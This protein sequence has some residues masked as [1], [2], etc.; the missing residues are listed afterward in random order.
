MAQCPSR[1][2]LGTWDPFVLALQ[3]G[4]NPPS[5]DQPGME[6]LL[7]GALGDLSPAPVTRVAFVLQVSTTVTASH[8][9]TA[10]AS[11]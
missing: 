5:R 11:D 9:I 7:L 3:L 10:W 8:V 1:G 4:P 2:C 6:M